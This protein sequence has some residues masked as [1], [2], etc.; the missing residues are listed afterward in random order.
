MSLRKTIVVKSNRIG[1]ESLQIF[2]SFMIWSKFF[3][4]SELQNIIYSIE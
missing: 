4:L 1:F 3:G 2:T